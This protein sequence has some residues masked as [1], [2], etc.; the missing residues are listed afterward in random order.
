VGSIE[1]IL[2]AVGGGA[3]AVYG[4][5]RC[6][7]PGLILTAVGGS[8]LDRGLSGH[9]TLYQTLS[10]NTAE[11]GPNTAIPAGQGVKMEHSVFVN[12]P[13]T[14]VFRFWRNLSN[15]PR[16]M[17]HLESVRTTGPKTSHW[18]AKGPLGMSFE[19]DAEIITEKTNEL[20]GWRSLPG[21]EVDTAGSVHFRPFGMGTEIQVVMKY[22]PP[23]GKAG[24]AIAKLFGKSAEQEMKE[25]LANLERVMQSSS[26]STASFASGP[27]AVGAPI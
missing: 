9:C 26:T 7:V 4:L 5:S 18:K 11:R 6:S 16:I 15:L 21:S 3:L 25:D 24:D 8:F 14:E 10:M 22:D 13:V 17:R 12:R 27:V 1:R 19:W 23:A 2:S 20:I